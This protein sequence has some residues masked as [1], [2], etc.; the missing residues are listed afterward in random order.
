MR[1]LSG[2]RFIT[3]DILLHRAPKYAEDL[4]LHNFKSSK[5]WCQKFKEI[6]KMKQRNLHRE[7]SNVEKIDYNELIFGIKVLVKKSG[8]TNV[9]NMDETGLFYKILPSKTICKKS[10]NGYKNFKRRKS[11]ILC[12]N[13]C[14]CEKMCRSLLEC[15]KTLVASNNSGCPI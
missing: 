14:G 3:D 9:F 4:N 5:G 15:S 2:S 13:I 6:N 8:E 10:R 7:T 1:E 12:T 11:I